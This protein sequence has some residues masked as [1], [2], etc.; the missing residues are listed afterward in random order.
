LT[1]IES[2][3]FHATSCRITFP[4]TILFIAHD[5]L[6]DASRL[7]LCDEELCPEFGRWRLS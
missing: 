6:S 7:S 2:E 1:R 5:A 4:S 3:A